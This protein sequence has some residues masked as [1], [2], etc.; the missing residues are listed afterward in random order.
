MERT[1]V[2]LADGAS[3]A[4][5]RVGE[6]RPLMLLVAARQYQNKQTIRV[7]PDRKTLTGG[8]RWGTPREN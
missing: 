3:L 4:A 8:W 5:L 2:Q 7:V 6:G 1:S